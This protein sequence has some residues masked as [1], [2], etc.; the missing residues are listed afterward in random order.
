MNLSELRRRLPSTRQ[1]FSAATTVR[2]VVQV[3]LSLQNRNI[4]THFTAKLQ[5]ACFFSLQ[6]QM[7][8]GVCALHNVGY[9]H[10]DIKVPLFAPTPLPLPLS[11]L[12]PATALKLCNWSIA[13][14]QAPVHYD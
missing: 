10:R 5:H 12:H 6:P 14:A 8:Q 3:Q 4:L 9:L 2:L 7:I 11:C 13:P 1:S